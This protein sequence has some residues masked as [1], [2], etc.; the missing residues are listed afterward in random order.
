[1]PREHAQTEMQRLDYPDG[2][3]EHHYGGVSAWSRR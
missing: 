3:F 2:M 1:M